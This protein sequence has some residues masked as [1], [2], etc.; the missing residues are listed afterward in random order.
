[1][2]I[3]FD[4]MTPQQVYFTLTQT[5]IPRPIAW[6]LSE[7]ADGSLNLA[8]F[9]Y[10]NAVSSNPPLIMMSAGL[11]PDGGAKDTRDNIRDRRDFVIH[12]PSLEQLDDMNASSASLPPGVSEVEHL[13]LET[14]AFEGSRLP[15]LVDPKVAFACSLYDIHYIGDDPQ[16]LILGE[17]HGVFVDDSVVGEDAKGRRKILAEKINPVGRLGAGEYVSFGELLSRTRPD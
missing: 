11:K 2:F 15:R 9:S 5:V 7:N 16:S 13:G 6:V 12:I 3:D 10:F 1:M 17:V 4:A 14:T 8:P